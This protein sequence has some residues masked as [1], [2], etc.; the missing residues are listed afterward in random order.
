MNITVNLY[1]TGKKVKEFVKEMTE[2]G[3]VEKIRNESGNLRYEYFFSAEDENT[4]LLIDSWENQEAIDNHH[5]TQMMNTIMSLRKKYNLS[6]KIERFINDENG[7]PEKDMKFIKN[8][9]L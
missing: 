4:V 3:T 5:K 9:N 6:V 1:Y 7:V 8:N 2:S